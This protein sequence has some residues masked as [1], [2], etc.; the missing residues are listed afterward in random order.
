VNSQ[1]CKIE[2]IKREEVVLMHLKLKMLHKPHFLL[3]THKTHHNLY[4]GGIT[5]FVLIIDSI[6]SYGVIIKF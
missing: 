5:T 4:M 1:S 2:Q 6:V 3:C